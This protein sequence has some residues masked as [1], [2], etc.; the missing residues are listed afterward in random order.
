MLLRDIT[1]RLLIVSLF[2]A[3]LGAV[4]IG[5]T[6]TKKST[7]SKPTTSA[8][9]APYAAA[10][11]DLIDINSASKKEL[12]ALPGIG[13]VYAQKIIDGRPYAMKTQLKS[14]KIVPDSTYDKIADKIIAKQAKP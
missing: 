13:D 9:A 11:A 14:K 12:M 8:T 1:Q 10:K 6:T 3:F 5:Q 7:T 2:T 4:A